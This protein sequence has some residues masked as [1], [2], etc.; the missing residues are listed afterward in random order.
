MITKHNMMGVLIEACPSF[1]SKWQAFLDEWREE[2]DDLPHYLALAD[3]ARHL[4]ELI[5]RGESASLTT[6]FAAVERLQVEGDQWVREA[7]TIG[8]LEDLQNLN[9][10]NTTNPEQFR[11]FLSPVSERWWDKLYRFW[12][13]GEVLTEE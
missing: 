7:A 11:Q 9:L 13:N 2:A 10:H 6:V 3:L 1:T 12:E 4:I 5:E 8:L